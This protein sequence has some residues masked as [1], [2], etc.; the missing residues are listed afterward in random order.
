[1]GIERGFALGEKHMVQYAGDALLSYTLE[2][3]ID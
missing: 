3:C 1:M 2:T